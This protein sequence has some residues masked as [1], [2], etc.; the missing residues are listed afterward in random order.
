LL[1]PRATNR[2]T[3]NLFEDMTK[4]LDRKIAST[5]APKNKINIIA[6]GDHRRPARMAQ[7][8]VRGRD[9]R[10]GTSREGRMT[11]AEPPCRVAGFC[12]ARN[13]GTILTNVSYVTF[14]RW[15]RR[16]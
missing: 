14:G 13:A 6:D 3:P 11:V 4:L 7:K 5:V 16:Y 1:Q 9:P 2:K 10:V 8:H 15:V 12:A